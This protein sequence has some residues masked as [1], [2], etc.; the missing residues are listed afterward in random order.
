MSEAL[1]ELSWPE[2]HSR[3]RQSLLVV[4]LGA[5]EQHGPHLPLCTDTDIALG[6]ATELARRRAAV[7]AP[8]IPY[9]AS[10]EH[11]GFAGTISVGQQAI[12]LL[13]LELVRSAST[14]F[15]RVLLICAHGGNR[16]AVA[17]AVTRLRNEGRAVRAFFPSWGGDA[18]AGRSETSLMLAL[19]PASVR[20]D[21]A[22]AGNRAPL[23]ELLPALIREGVRAVSANGVLGDPAGADEQEG[24]RLL[25]HALSQLEQLLERWDSAP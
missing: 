8:A 23:Q 19:R 20:I 10:G 5:T 2:A 3:A 12:E 7:V 6:L 21:R 25:E 15:G 24:R 14:S 13:L 4:P 17:R 16:E 1:A 9:G 11:D 18:H 22:E